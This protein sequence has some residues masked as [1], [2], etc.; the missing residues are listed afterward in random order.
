MVNNK[1]KFL[2]L[3]LF[4]FAIGNSLKAQTSSQDDYINLQLAE[5]NEIVSKKAESKLN[6]CYYI[7]DINKGIVKNLSIKKYKNG[8][9][10][11]EWIGFSNSFGNFK[12]DFIATYKN[13]ELNGYYLRTDNHTFLEKGYYKKGGKDGIWIE[14][15]E[16][17]KESITY[18]K[19]IVC[20]NY[21]S[22]NT[23][24]NILIEGKYKKGE[25]EGV[26]I[27]K[28]KIT[29]EETKQIFKKGKLVSSID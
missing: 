6:G 12:Q 20:G 8:L 24:D 29:G 7:T 18:S 3:I 1:K 26:W 28:D 27:T 23:N 17:V 25:K 21:T 9:R 11:G 5:Y 13:N 10:D 14:E 2:L 19:G 4:V 15:K 22:N 16:G